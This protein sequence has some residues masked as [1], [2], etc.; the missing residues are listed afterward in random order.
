MSPGFA[1]P[2]PELLTQMSR[3]LL[4]SPPLLPK[5]A[6]LPNQPTTPTEAGAAGAHRAA[7]VA[8]AASTAIPRRSFE[9]PREESIGAAVSGPRPVSPNR[10]TPI[11]TRSP[12]PV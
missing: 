8:T 3:G 6:S 7:Y 10:D 5:P 11:F 1:R 4:I 9:T 12:V 2:A